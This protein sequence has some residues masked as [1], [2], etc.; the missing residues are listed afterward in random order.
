[1]RTA[2]I[3]WGEGGILEI[4]IFT[5]CPNEFGHDCTSHVHEKGAPFE[6]TMSS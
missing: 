1:M 6:P 3:E 4:V 2:N 5:C